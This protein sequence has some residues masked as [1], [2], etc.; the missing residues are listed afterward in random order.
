MSGQPGDAI[1][2]LMTA[3][4]KEEAARLANMLVSSHLAACVQ[5][6]PE[7]ESIYRWEG[8][9]E[10]QAEI[11]LIAKS[12]MAKF[13]DL[14]R[15]VRVFHSYDVP[16]IVAIPLVAGSIPYLKWISAS[17]DSEEVRP[18]PDPQTKDG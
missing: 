15:K 3:A 10:R 2:V 1:V 18:A 9:V 8:S 11:L 6:L 13:P 5:I 7:M 17:L 16:E 12:T 14:E 4:N